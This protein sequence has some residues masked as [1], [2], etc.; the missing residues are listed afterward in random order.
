MIGKGLC[1]GE[2][3]QHGKWP[4]DEGFETLEACSAECQKRPGCTGFDLTPSQDL[5]GKFRCILYG[6]DDLQVADSLSLQITK[7]YRMIGRSAI[8][9]VTLQDISF[10]FLPLDG[11]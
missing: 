3:W 9:E 8:G 10:Y 4:Q 5:K 6:H 7:C 1:R 2:N 11:F